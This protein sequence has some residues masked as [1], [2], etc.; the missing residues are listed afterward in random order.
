[1][2]IINDWTTIECMDDKSLPPLNEWVICE[3]ES[4]S[5]HN[6]NPY[7]VLK[8]IPYSFEPGWRWFGGI[9]GK[10]GKWKKI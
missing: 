9:T 4:I 1:M 10:P 3:L 7:N 6:S 5:Y 8:R 2:K